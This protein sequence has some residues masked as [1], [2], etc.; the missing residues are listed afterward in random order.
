M[1][2]YVIRHGESIANATKTHAGWAQIPLSEKGKLQAQ[3][4]SKNLAQISFTRVIASDLLRAEQT[5]KLALPTYTYDTDSRLREI[6]VGILSGQAISKCRAELGEEYISNVKEF[7][8]I[9]YGGENVPMHYRRVSAFMNAITNEREDSTIAV[10]CHEGTIVAM[11]SHVLQT[12]VPRR[13]ARV[14]NCGICAF[15]YSNGQWILKKWN[16]TGSPTLN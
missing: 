15:S 3:S 4:I 2:L 6:D 10:V 5:A 16:E 1:D 7:N 12:S 11:L 14:M 13:V 8:F 9:P